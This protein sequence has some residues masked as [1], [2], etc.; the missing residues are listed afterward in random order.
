[1]PEYDVEYNYF[2]PAE[3]WR[4]WPVHKMIEADWFEIK[5]ATLHFFIVGPEP[6]YL[7][8]EIFAIK[9]W[10]SVREIPV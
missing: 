8:R 6:M 2:H 10:M 4:P 5:S 1:M 3:P 7:D 9:E